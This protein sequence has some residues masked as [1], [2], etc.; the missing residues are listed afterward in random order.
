MKIRKAFAHMLRQAQH[1]LF[2]LLREI[3]WLTNLKPVYAP[4]LHNS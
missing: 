1:D 3:G 2:L 4:S